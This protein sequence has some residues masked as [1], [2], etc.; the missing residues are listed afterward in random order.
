VKLTTKSL[1]SVGVE[2]HRSRSA[3]AFKTPRVAK[4]T[5]L[6]I[7]EQAFLHDLSH[8]LNH[9]AHLHHTG[10]TVAE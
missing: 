6:L 9:L 5:P 8:Q 7:V 1:Q 10:T 4:K 3:V 2:S